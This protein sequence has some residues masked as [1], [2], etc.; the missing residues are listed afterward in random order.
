MIPLRDTNPTE[1]T[2]FVTIALVV[3]N[4]LV[5][6]VELLFNT[7][8]Q[9]EPFI[10]NFGVIP[11]EL[12]RHPGGEWFTLFSS[13]FMHGGWA[14]L[15]GN[16]LY[17]WVFGDNVEDRLGHGRFLAFYLLT[18]L[19]AAAAQIAIRPDSTVPTIGASGAIAGVLGGYLI[20]FPK[21]QVTTLVIRFVTR[22]PAV[23]V[24]G[25]WFVYQFL[26]GVASLGTMDVQ[27]GGI[28]FFAHIGGFVAG[29]LLVLPFQVGRLSRGGGQQQ[30]PWP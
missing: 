18:G 1:G 19:I 12:L 4:V 2:A 23:I 26:S 29:M 8:G 25:F 5:Y 11:A 24:L 22:V 6:L 30:L 21:A 16:M 10:Q 14:H 27:T 17:L 3:L 7:Q 9:L 28:A 15:L 13:M 20:L